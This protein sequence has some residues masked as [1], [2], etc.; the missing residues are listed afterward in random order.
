MAVQLSLPGEIVSIFGSNLG[1]PLPAGAI[2]DSNP[3]VSKQTANTQVL[4][5]G[6]P[7]AMVYASA[8]QTSRDRAL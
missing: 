8:N 5:D 6:V 7:A 1:P 2:L 3:L 4:F